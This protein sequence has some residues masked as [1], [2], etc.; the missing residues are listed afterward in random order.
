MTVSH[1]INEHKY[2]KDETRERVLDAIARLDYRVNHAARNLR[3]GRTGAI[4]LALPEI[5]SHYFGQFA[6]RI[7]ELAERRGYRVAVEQ[8]GRSRDSELDA[9]TLSRNR[10][11]DGLILSTVGLGQEDVGLLQVDHPVVIL[12][13][14]IFDGPLDHIA[15]PNV[16]G[17]DAAVSHLLD[18][19]CRRILILDGSELAEVS[20]HALRL[21]GYQLALER[22]GIEVDPE[23]VIALKRTDMPAGRD[24]IVEAIARG[25]DFDGVFC[26]TDTLAIGA[27]RGLADAG[28]RVPNDVK[29]IGYDDISESSYLVPSLSSIAPDHDAMART[30]LDRLLARITGKALDPI[31]YVSAFEVVARESTGEA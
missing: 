17:A 13:E 10:L 12:G 4:G 18:R 20:M 7:I 2:V 19:G 28:L 6:A 8:T 31:E 27:L 1:V 3:T 26:V 11:Y 9:L 22:R 24:A 15:M 25:I 30:A 29:V 16:S 21:E 14:R 5:D 23:L